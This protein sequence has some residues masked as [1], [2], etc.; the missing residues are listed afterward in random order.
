MSEEAALHNVLLSAIRGAARGLARDFGEL[1]ELQGAPAKVW[2]FSRRGRE[3]ARQRL[4]ESLSKA[5]PAYG[6]VDERESIPGRDPNRYW[7]VEP[8]SGLAN[9]AHAV[10]HIAIVGAVI[11]KGSPELAIMY[12]PVSQE[13]FSAQRGRG[14][15]REQ[16]RLRVSGRT[17]LA[18]CLIAVTLPTA[19]VDT[20]AREQALMDVNRVANFG[21]TVGGTGCPAVDFAWVAAGRYDGA[22]LRGG[23]T[24]AGVAGSLL[25]TEAGGRF[26]LPD[27]DAPAEALTLAAP[28]TLLDPLTQAF[29]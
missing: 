29:A 19:E 28:A 26:S 16:R 20:Q 25:V 17:K 6:W 4:F 3:V 7:A 27:P 13:L 15:M 9:F 2:E 18:D 14:A 11:H 21:A 10:P 24:I 12:D 8:I 23:H 1:G 22:C 5:R